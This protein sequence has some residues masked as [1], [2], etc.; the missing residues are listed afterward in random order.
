MKPKTIVLSVLVAAIAIFL[1]YQVLAA[2]NP[3]EICHG[4]IVCGDDYECG[5]NSRE[6]YGE[7]IP[8]SDKVCPE[9]FGPDKPD[10]TTSKK[11]Y[12]IDCCKINN[13]TINTNDCGDPASCGCDDK[14]TLNISYEDMCPNPAYIVVEAIG[15]DQSSCYFSL[16]GGYDSISSRGMEFRCEGEINQTTGEIEMPVSCS[17]WNIYFPPYCMGAEMET[18]NVYMYADGY[19]KTFIASAT[20]NV[21]F[22]LSDDAC[23]STKI[24]IIGKG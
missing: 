8:G 11:C 4:A 24:E 22:Q 7:I 19:G 5:G 1:I 2:S 17:G 14:I 18:V 20:T 3:L 10:C 9:W 6:A 23:K 15:K 21:D 16:K 13:V 12:D